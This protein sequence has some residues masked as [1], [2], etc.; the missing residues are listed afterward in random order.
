MV[1]WG[2]LVD[3]AINS[4]L[5]A[6]FSLESTSLCESHP[7]RSGELW[8]FGATRPPDPTRLTQDANVL[9][10]NGPNGPVNYEGIN[11]GGWFRGRVLRRLGCLESMPH[12]GWLGWG[13]GFRPVPCARFPPQKGNKNKKSPRPPFLSSHLINIK[14]AGHRTCF[15]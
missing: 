10:Q 13:W 1:R 14:F 11:H 15:P 8:K 12:L 2:R 9:G 3:L 7:R 4:M 5:A 6:F